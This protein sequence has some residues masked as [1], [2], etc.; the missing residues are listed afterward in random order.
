MTIEPVFWFAKEAVTKNLLTAKNRPIKLMFWT[1][2]SRLRDKQN[3]DVVALDNNGAG[4][5][6]GQTVVKAVSIR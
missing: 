2:K 4:K 3:D 1:C 6:G 5:T